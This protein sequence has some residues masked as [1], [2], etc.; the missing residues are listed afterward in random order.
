MQSNDESFAGNSCAS[1]DKTQNFDAI[2]ILKA[3]LAKAPPIENLEIHLDRDT[4]RLDV[5]L[6][7]EFGHRSSGAPGP[8]FTIHVYLNAIS[9][10]PSS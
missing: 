7:Q 6:P 4:F 9:H 3:L 10:R 5:Q 8:G 2:A 1:A